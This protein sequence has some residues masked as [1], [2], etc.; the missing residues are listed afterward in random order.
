MPKLTNTDGYNTSPTGFGVL[1]ILAGIVGVILLFGL[2]IGSLVSLTRTG[3]TQVAL[4]RNGGPFDNKSIRQIIPPQSSFK[5]PGLFTDC[6]KYIAGNEQRYYTISSVPNQGDRPG[7]DYVQV[8]TKDGVQVSLEA[9]MYFHTAFTDAS[10]KPNEA[11]LKTFD[12]EYG[13]RTFDG[14]HPYD[15]TDGWQ[16]FLDVIVRPV[17]DN[18]VREEI[19]QYNCADLVSSCALIQSQGQV[20]LSKINGEAN[21]RNFQAVQDAIQNRLATGINSALGGEY[22]NQFQF[23]LAKVRLPTNVQGSIDNAQASFADIAKSQAE[24][25]Q[26][27]FTAQAKALLARQY[28]K[29]PVQAYVDAVHAAPPGST[30]IIGS[31]PFVTPT[32][33][34]PAGK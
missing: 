31:Q 13:N 12:T 34:A 24:L 9:T 16:K 19:G 7:V 30:V 5:I 18:A 23:R 20:D 17:I 26:A 2:V 15:G 6:R 3:P 29:S 11:L 8:P 27:Q 4:C 28:A 14:S 25:K 22:L 21:S 32:A 33:S 10:G 1:A